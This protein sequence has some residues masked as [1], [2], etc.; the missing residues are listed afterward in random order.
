MAKFNGNVS[1]IQGTRSLCDISSGP[2]VKPGEPWVRLTPGSPLGQAP[3]LSCVGG[4]WQ[5]P[6]TFRLRRVDRLAGFLRTPGDTRHYIDWLMITWITMLS[7]FVLQHTFCDEAF[8]RTKAVQLPEQCW[9]LSCQACQEPTDK[10]TL[11]TSSLQRSVSVRSR[12]EVISM[13]TPSTSDACET[14]A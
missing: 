9:Y 1:S 14:H 11:V 8:P 6:G 4:S 12:A 2:R 7:T 5:V 3:V 10:T 13:H